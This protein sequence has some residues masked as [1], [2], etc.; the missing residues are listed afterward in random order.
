METL[1]KEKSIRFAESY[2]WKHWSNDKIVQFQLSQKWLCMDFKTFQR[3]LETVLNRPVPV[4]E[5]N[6]PDLLRKEYYR[7]V[8]KANLKN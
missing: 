2:A 8:K 6:F 4:C 1:T 5:F 3:A 7:T